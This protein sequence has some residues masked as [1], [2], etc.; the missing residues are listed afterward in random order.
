MFF[1]VA[2]VG[3]MG[4]PPFQQYNAYIPFGELDVYRMDVLQLCMDVSQLYFLLL[5]HL[6]LLSAGILQVLCRL[7]LPPCWC[8]A[9]WPP[10]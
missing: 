2:A 8:A 5:T 3:V 1:V 4:L 9:V 6:L 10:G 7:H